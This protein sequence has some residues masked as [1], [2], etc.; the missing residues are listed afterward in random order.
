MTTDLS[1]PAGVSATLSPRRL[2]G[3]STSRRIWA[4]ARSRTSAPPTWRRSGELLK[5]GLA[6]KSVRNILGFLHSVFDHGIDR[7]WLRE[8]ERFL[9]LVED[10]SRSCTQGPAGIGW[11]EG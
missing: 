4:T 1:G 8:K 5:D 10:T 11:R 3:A 6:P 9:E 2:W 7:D